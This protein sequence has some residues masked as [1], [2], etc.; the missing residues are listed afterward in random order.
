MSSSFVLSYA[1]TPL[2]A[3]VDISTPGFL[4]VE[5]LSPKSQAVNSAS[6]GLSVS[7]SSSHLDTVTVA[8][9]H[10]DGQQSDP[11]SSDPSI[12]ALQAQIASLFIVDRFSDEDEDEDDLDGTA[13]LSQDY[14]IPM[15]LLQEFHCQHVSCTVNAEELSD[16]HQGNSTAIELAQVSDYILDNS[17]YDG[18]SSRL[19]AIHPATQ[20][21]RPSNLDEHRP[22]SFM[23]SGDTVQALFDGMP[24]EDDDV[25]EEEEMESGNAWLNQSYTLPTDFKDTSVKCVPRM[26]QL[27]ELPQP[28]SVVVEFL[29]TP[30]ERMLLKEFKYDYLQYTI[31]RHASADPAIYTSPPGELGPSPTR[32]APEPPLSSPSSPPRQPL[33]SRSL[34]VPSPSVP[35]RK[36]LDSGSSCLELKPLPSPPSPPPKPKK[37]S[38]AEDVKAE[39]RTGTT[40]KRPSP[41][42]K[43]CDFGQPDR[44][45]VTAMVDRLNRVSSGH[46]SPKPK[47]KSGS[48]SKILPKEIIKQRRFSGGYRSAL[49]KTTPPPPPSVKGKLRDKENFRPRWR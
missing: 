3:Q 49:L 15:D 40:P 18:S 6:P 27:P 4:S 16:I 12:V 11:L 36:C 17:L 45:R 8:R 26:E 1:L 9:S 23:V 47:R 29:N 21:K 38:S 32:S 14:R 43:V 22:L 33:A 28:H 37:S 41:L 34:S 10:L 46:R 39:F 25:E 7:Q 42:R 30:M 5:R 13:W 44:T 20:V 19:E 24:F 35:P 48:R 2:Q 31:K